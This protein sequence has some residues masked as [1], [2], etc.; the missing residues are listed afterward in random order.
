MTLTLN[1]VNK[2]SIAILILVLWGVLGTTA[3]LYLYFQQEPQ[4]I[5]NSFLEEQIM[6][7]RHD[8]ELKQ[9]DIDYRDSQMSRRDGEIDSLLNLKPEIR[10]EYVTIY[11]EIDNSS[12]IDLVELSDSILSV[13]G[14]SH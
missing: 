11:K 13:E 7:L 10:T 2:T 9:L 4:H 14:I 5:D 8:N 3:A 12:V 6:E 1:F